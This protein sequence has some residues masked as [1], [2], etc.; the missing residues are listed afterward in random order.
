[1]TEQVFVER[2]AKG[3]V[4]CKGPEVGVYP[5]LQIRRMARCWCGWKECKR[6]RV[7]GVRHERR[8]RGYG[9]WNWLS[10]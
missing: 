7:A 1:M 2:Y 4:Q 5:C 8:A 6:V 10:L 9:D 3:Q